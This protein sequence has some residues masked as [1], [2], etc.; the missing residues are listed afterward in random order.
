[1][2]HPAPVP[3]DALPCPACQTTLSDDADG[4]RCPSCDGLLVHRTWALRAAPELGAPALQPAFVGDGRARHCP[5]CRKSMGPVLCH[6]VLSWSCARCRWLFFDG[7][8]RRALLKPTDATPLPA[9]T[10]AAPT[11][12][13][14]VADNARAVTPGQLKDTMGI[15]VLAALVLVALLFEIKPG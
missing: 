12:L 1:M 14:V 15:V 5:M 7:P 6:G 11:L 2:S 3:L 13:Q 8:H 10:L 4:T 9:R